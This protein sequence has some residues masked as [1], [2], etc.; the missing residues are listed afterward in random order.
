MNARSI[1]LSLAVNTPLESWREAEV[2]GCALVA[3]GFDDAQMTG[4]GSDGGIDVIARDAVCQVKFWDASVGRGEVQ[5]LFGAALGRTAIFLAPTFTPK[6]R[7]W[8]D[9]AG[10]ALFSFDRSALILAEN[11]AAV[12]LAAKY[13]PGV[14]SSRETGFA[15]RVTRTHRWFGVIS[16]EIQ[17]L[18]A[19]PPASNRER[20]RNKRRADA[21]RERL[22]DIQ[23]GFAK[24]QQ[25]PYLRIAPLGRLGHRLDLLERELKGA[26]R[27]LGIKLP[28]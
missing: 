11:P 1:D 8:A 28:A 27:D 15:T 10:V 16:S 26:A 3:V 25:T 4:E 7:Q 2:L 6:A 9:D 21:A 18:D 13:R 19:Q 14:L 22:P 20:R 5:K 12:A 23:Q 17:R 24:V